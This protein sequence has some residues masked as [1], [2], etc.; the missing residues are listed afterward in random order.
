[1]T[2]AEKELQERLKFLDD[3]DRCKGDAKDWC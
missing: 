2:D 1:M 3:P